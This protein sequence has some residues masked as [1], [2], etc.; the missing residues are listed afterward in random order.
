VLCEVGVER[1][2]ERL[3]ALVLAEGLQKCA[4]ALVF[5]DERH[6]LGQHSDVHHGREHLTVGDGERIT[7]ESAIFAATLCVFFQAR[8]EFREPIRQFA[9]VRAHLVL[10]LI[11]A[12]EGRA[13]GNANQ[14]LGRVHHFIAQRT[15]QRILRVHSAQRTDEANAR[16]RLSE[17]QRIAAIRVQNRQLRD[18]RPSHLTALLGRLEIRLRDE[19]VL[20][21]HAAQC[22]RQSQRLAATRESVVFDA[23]RRFGL[24]DFG[25]LDG[26]HGLNE[27][28]RVFE[29]IVARTVLLILCEVGVECSFERLNALVFA[30]RL[31]KRAESL[32]FANELH[33]LRQHSHV[34]HCRKDFAVG[35]RKTITD[36]SAVGIPSLGILLQTR[37]EFGEPIRQF[38]LIRTHL[39]LFC[40]IA[41]ERRARR[42]SDQILGRVHHF[43][44]QRAQQRILWVHSAQRTDEAN[45]RIALSQRHRIA[46]VLIEHRQLRHARPSHFAALLCRFELGL[47]NE[48][49]LEGH[50]AQRRRQS[51]RFAT[52]RKRI[53]RDAKRTARYAR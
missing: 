44:A 33:A 34:N 17:R 31:Q 41:A 2:F 49:I 32:V 12:A 7:N 42:D 23:E 20:E 35:D 27:F 19:A 11:I 48:A 47:R 5:A 18:A 46:A 52:P 10:F 43:V 36:K 30:K 53:V 9:L 39:V 8:F 1:C 22:R 28:A 37:L 16:I 26:L 24:C 13:R 14:I 51:Q 38:A 15:E 4:E 3:Y 45:A 6:A 50:T 40:V 21:G 29:V 25:H